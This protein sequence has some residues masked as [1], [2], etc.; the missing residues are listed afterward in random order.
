MLGRK[1]KADPATANPANGKTPAASP[2]KRKR[3]RSGRGVLWVIMAMFAVS[4]A[5]RL[6]GETG[7]AIANVSDT[8]VEHS[9]VGA[10]LPACET[11]DDIATAL[12]LLRSREEKVNDREAAL[13]D[14]MQALAVAE[15]QIADRMAELKQAE[16]TLRSTMATASTAAEDDLARLT[17]VYENMKA[18]EAVPLFS[19]MD[20]QFAAGFLGRMRADAAAAIL[21]GLDPQKAYTISVLL[22]GRNANAPTE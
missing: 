12:T 14:R 9:T 2:K 21:S 20:P 15:K 17:S 1:A 8:F 13:S 6:G 16:E 3:R 22:A 4:G 7:W 18:K 5:L 19:E 11:E 10:P